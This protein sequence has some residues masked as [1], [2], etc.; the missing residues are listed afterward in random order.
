MF[1]LPIIL[2][3]LFVILNLVATPVYAARPAGGGGAPKTDI[4][5]NDI[6]FPQC[7]GNYPSGQAFGIVGVTG[8]LANT[9][10][11]CLSSE[12]TWAN[13]SVGGT[14]QAKVQLY[15]N[16]ANPAGLGTA[17]WPTSNTDPIGNTTSNPYGTC[18]GSNSLACAW[19]YGWN[20]AV[21]DVQIRFLPAAQSA[22]ISTDPAS[23]PWWL[24]VETANSW[25]TGSAFAFES[26]V[27]DLEGM[28]TYFQSRGVKVGVY[29]TGY[30]WGEI[31]GTLN[32]NS[33][34]NG[35]DSWLAGARRLAS[36]KSNCSLAPLTP[37]GRVSIT[38]YVTNTFDYDYS[39]I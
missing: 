8:G 24:D 5:G 17:S 31:V 20:R 11:P 23:Y 39:C 29:S 33:N 15:V 14:N 36:A 10:N 28:V 32:P 2:I 6:S 18:D 21:E 38:Q 16:T 34:L 4:V 37:T 35:L 1:K 3:N 13:S 25:L 19:Q 9:T 7:G 27:A 12:L 30:Q 22:G 26:N